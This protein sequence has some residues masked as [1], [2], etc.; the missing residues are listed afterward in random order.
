[1]APDD[2]GITPIRR[3]PRGE[4]PDHGDET[5]RPVRTAD[6]AREYARKRLEEWRRC[7]G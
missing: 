1:M 6:E 2:W 3:E 4:F 5:P 7:H